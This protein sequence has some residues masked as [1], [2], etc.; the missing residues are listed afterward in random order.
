MKKALFLAIAA[1][2]ACSEDN[3]ETPDA[4]TTPAADATVHEDAAVNEDAEPADTG[5][6]APYTITALDYARISSRGGAPNFH[7]VRGDV[8]FRDGPFSNAKMIVSLDTTCYPFEKWADNPPPQGHNWPADC[9]AFDRNFE[10]HLDPPSSSTGAP[11]LE[12]LRAITPFGGPMTIEIDVTDLA[13][14]LPG[15]HVAQ[16]TIPT[17]SDGAGQ[18]SGSDGGWKVTLRFEMTPGP[19]PRN[20]L[21]VVPLLDLDH[22]SDTA[23]RTI[24]VETPAGTVD[25]RIEYRVTGHGG[26]AP[27]SRCIGPAEEFCRRTHSI[28]VDGALIDTLDAWRENCDDLCTIT[29]QGPANGGFDYCLE[30]PCGA[31]QSVRAPRANWCPGSVTPPAVWNVAELNMPGSHTFGYRISEVLPGGVWRVSATYYAFGR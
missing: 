22:T 10:V 30:N 12:V 8:D 25:S 16:V 26:G 1:L 5:P 9:D 28:F 4:G 6:A 29:H 31:I 19:A 15:R 13:N 21:A 14:G 2:S 17:Y 24:A 11:G 23:T 7:R 3:T 18:V 20:V 27:G